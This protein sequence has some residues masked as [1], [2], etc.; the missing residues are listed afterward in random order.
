LFSTQSSTST[1]G[2]RS[3]TSFSTSIRADVTKLAAAFSALSVSNPMSLQAQ[4][5][6]FGY[7]VPVLQAGIGIDPIQT[8][9]ASTALARA[10]IT[11]TKAGTWIR[12]MAVRAMPGTAIFES[13]KKGRAPRRAI[14]ADRSAR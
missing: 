2:S 4:E 14:E 6:A 13:E 9:A 8:M 1:L 12:E 11:S 10:G 5:R 3:S 7:A